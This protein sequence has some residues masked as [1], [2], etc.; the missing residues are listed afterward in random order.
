M[1]NKLP[2]VDYGNGSYPTDFPVMRPCDSPS[3]EAAHHCGSRVCFGQCYDAEATLG[4]SR[5]AQ[6][7]TQSR[8]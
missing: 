5:V 8:R 6:C 1:A 2:N 3:Q 7:L 4:K